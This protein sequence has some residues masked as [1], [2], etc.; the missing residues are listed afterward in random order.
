MGQAGLTAAADGASPAS[1][2]VAAPLVNNPGEDVNLLNP[3]DTQSDTT[4]VVIPPT[5]ISAPRIVTAF[6]DTGSLDPFGQFTV[7]GAAESKLTGYSVSSDG[8]NSFTDLGTTP[9]NLNGDLGDPTLARDNQTGTVYLTTLPF[10]QFFNGPGVSVFRS[11]DGGATFILPVNAAPGVNFSDI[12]DKPWSTVDNFPGIGRGNVYEVFTD[13]GPTESV[14]FTRSINGGRNFGP[15]GG[16][17]IAS[18]GTGGTAT[19]AYVTVGPD[20]AVYVF[21]LQQSGVKNSPNLIKMVKSTDQGV[22]FGSPVT[23]ATLVTTKPGGD[24]GL[25]GFHGNPFRTNAFPQAVVNPTDPKDIYLV[26]DDVGTKPGDKAEIYFV[27]SSDGGSTWSARTRVNDDSTTNDQWQPTV[28]VTPDGTHVGVFWYDRRADPKNVLIDRFGAIADLRLG[29]A[30]TFP[31]NFAYNQV[32]FPPVN[33]LDPIASPEYMGDYDQTVADNQFFYTTWGDNR[34]PSAAHAGNNADVRFSK[35]PVSGL[36]TK[37]ANVLVNNPVEVR[38]NNP[39]DTQNETA[40][41][42][43][44]GSTPTIVSAFNDSSSFNFYLRG[45]PSNHFI[46]YSQSTNGGASFIDKGK[47]PASAM[48][49]GSDPVL[50]RDN[51]SGKIYL[52]VV[53]FAPLVSAVAAI[54]VFPSTDNGATFDA[55]VNSAPGFSPTDLL[56]KPWITVDNAAG[57]GQGNVYQVFTDI[58]TTGGGVFLTRSTDGG[59]TWG[60]SGGTKIASADFTNTLTEG[61]NVVVGPDHSVYVFYV[62][63]NLFSGSARIVM[64]KSTDFGVTFGQPILVTTLRTTGVSGDLN[65]TDAIGRSFRSNAFPQAAV[66]PVTG[67]IYVV[68]NDVGT[69]PG[70]KAD[71]YFRQSTNGGAAWGR[72]IKVNDDKTTNDQW[73]PGL[74][75]TP[76]GS[77]IGVFWYDR[78]NDPANNLIDRFGAIATLNGLGVSFGQN[79]RVTT[80]SFAPSFGQDFLLASNYMGDY[81]Q[82]AADNQ[83]F[84]TTWGDNSLASQAH[85]GFNPDV[86]FAKIRVTTAPAALQ[87]TMA[88]LGT[89]GMELVAAP[90][91]GSPSMDQTASV[92]RASGASTPNR[93]PDSVSRET[94]SLGPSFSSTEARRLRSDSSAGDVFSLAALD[95][96]FADPINSFGSTKGGKTRSIR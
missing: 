13:I 89:S 72:Q 17:L 78:R 52:S 15:A 6:N 42:V 65:L 37:P 47:L 88:A 48:G 64:R 87:P 11:Y 3:Q 46:G 43:V 90:A 50:A 76:D 69:G 7:Q 55:S 49:D 34:S 84:Y 85:A 80:H 54:S 68:Y 28:A 12:I 2:N 82:V 60:P 35:I 16:T 94:P 45:V 81:D 67:A 41:V 63:Q 5:A 71:V 58:A 25:I 62:L 30:V 83:F 91:S 92:T 59:A 95:D 22:T 10:G 32:T 44:P 74:A 1:Q 66:N 73:Q 20:H 24:L 27:Q 33:G 18:G 86:R 75:V 70:D 4:L 36:T 96:F 19:G 77:H 23:V 8:G 39:A 9:T 56:D 31:T 57:K 40:L 53:P 21:W 79:F 14:R 29:K 26:F 61:A 38:L 51:V 93:S